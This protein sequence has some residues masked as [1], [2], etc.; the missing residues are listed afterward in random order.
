MSQP[1]AVSSV[2]E[3]RAVHATVL[4]IIDMLSDWTF[5][6][7]DALIGP[8]AA[9]A[10]AIAAL[11]A[12]CREAGVPVIYANDNQGRWRSD[13]RQV[14]EKALDCGG[15]PREIAEALKPDADDYF[16][17]KPKHSAFFSTPL[18]LLLQHLQADRLILTG[19]ATD[20]CIV[21]T[22]HDARMRDYEVVVA[23]D[24]TATQSTE[25]QQRALAQL[26]EAMTVPVPDSGE[27]SLRRESA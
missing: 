18:E 2:A 13:F 9:I 20:Q 6:D 11:K 24:C 19:V 3:D 1:P 8:A 4:L 12:R 15:T 21:S 25:R 14:L 17:L 27:L 22:A 23:A 7:A 5:P 16:I 26:A 10:P